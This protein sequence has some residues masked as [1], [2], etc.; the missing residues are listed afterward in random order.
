MGQLSLRKPGR[1]H[2]GDEGGAAILEFVIVLP[3]FLFV[4]F[5]LIGTAMSFSYRQALSQAATE[6]ARSAAVQPVHV[7]AAAR[8]S[9]A[10]DAINDTV[11]NQADLTCGTG[12]LV[13]D[14]SISA[15]VVTVTLSHNL[16]ANPLGPMAVIQGMP[17][18]GDVLPHQLDYTASARV[19]R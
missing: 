3:F 19:S 11:R 18:V 14:V 13:C 6:G 16:R 12:G 4:I 1:R 15:S 7:S 9:A 8:R 5:F 17:L 10:T 2:N